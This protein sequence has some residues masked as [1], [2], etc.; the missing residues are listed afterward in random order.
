MSDPKPYPNLETDSN[1][2]ITFKKVDMTFIC[3]D[4]LDCIKIALK[5]YYQD[6]VNNKIHFRK[7]II[8]SQTKAS[9][10]LIKILEDEAGFLIVPYFPIDETI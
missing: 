8:N 7:Q 5:R 2:E 1:P 3:D 9:E 10:R 6:L 4:E